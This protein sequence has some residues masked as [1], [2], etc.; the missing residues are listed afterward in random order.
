MNYTKI[1][2]RVGNV[3]VLVHLKQTDSFKRCHN[4]FVIY[5]S[6]HIIVCMCKLEEQKRKIL[7]GLFEIMHAFNEFNIKTLFT[8]EL[9]L[10][11]LFSFQHSDQDIY[12][13]LPEMVSISYCLY[14]YFNIT[15]SSKVLSGL[16]DQ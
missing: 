9:F 8:N 2:Q 4:C 7:Y 14:I 10:N 5:C 12:M 13:G 15:I 16:L 1:E 11:S 3:G 6:G